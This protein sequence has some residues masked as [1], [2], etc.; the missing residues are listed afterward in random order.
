M[1]VIDRDLQRFKD[2]V[3]GR[4][5]R[6]LR[7]WMGQSELFGKK[8]DEV[9]SIPVPQIELPRL[10]YGDNQR[11][12]VGQGEGEPGDSAEGGKPGDGA[13]EAG[14]QAGEHV[15][16][17]DLSIDELAEILGEELELPRIE[18]RGAAG[19][20]SQKARYTSISRRGP[21][22]LRH[23]KRT[24][25]EALKRQIAGGAYDPD[26]PSVIPYRE[27]R[28]YRAANVA[29]E[30]VARAAVLYMMDVSGS[31]G[32]EQKAI[33]RNEVFWIDAWLR[34]HYQ[35]LVTRFIIHDAG[36]REV[37]RETFFHTREA[38]GTVI[39]TAYR[40]AVDIITADYPAESW[41]VYPFHFSDG[42]NLGQRDNEVA[43]ALLRD[44][45]MP[46]VN[47]FGYAQTESAYGSA[48][49]FHVL[50]EAFPD[51]DRVVLS[52]VPNRD[53]VLDS[54]RALLGRGH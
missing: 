25:K 53:A 50:A 5:R 2:V 43:V 16:E 6:D 18:P 41:N 12:G 38:G 15:L 7:R 3:R 42:D 40:L 52:R 11:Q 26:R 31:M 49:F 24:F 54:I 23:G 35:G 27:D 29:P 39:S 17:V 19:V 45:L 13:G 48:R 9:V 21:E 47:Q 34:K 32:S 14:D 10:R 51:D 33:V 20:E 37:D 44:E 4:V 22:S 46:R 36:A 28:R 1:L 30:P 8:G